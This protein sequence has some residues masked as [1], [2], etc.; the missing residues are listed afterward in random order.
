MQIYYPITAVVIYIEVSQLDMPFQQSIKIRGLKSG[1]KMTIYLYIMTIFDG[2][3]NPYDYKRN[4]RK[5]YE[6]ISKYISWP[7]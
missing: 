1:L 4:S 7:L 2:E 5:Q 6:A 3:K